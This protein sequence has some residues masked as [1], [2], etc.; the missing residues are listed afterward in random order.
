MNFKNSLITCIQKKYS[1]F[2]GRASRSE[3]WFFYLF[4]IISYATSILIISFVSFKFFWA[5][6]I[7]AIGMFLP[8]IAVSV[9][10]LHDINKSGWYILLPFPFDL[11]SRLLETSDELA[12][13]VSAFISL[14]LYIYLFVLY[15]KDGDRKNN[16]FGKNIYI[17]TIKKKK[18]KIPNK[19]K[20]LR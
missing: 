15:C 12:S 1:G 3:F 11:A 2:S 17:N 8:A 10:R 19:R 18:R 14:G 6:L 20:L 16:D 9:R 13:L 4:L 5:F 7:F